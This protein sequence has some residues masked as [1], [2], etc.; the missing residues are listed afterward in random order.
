MQSNDKDPMNRV[1]EAITDETPV[2]WAAEHSA[3]PKHA[4]RL[5]RLR[6]LDRIADVHRTA[7]EPDEGETWMERESHK[8]GKMVAHFAVNDTVSEAV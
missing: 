8:L 4:S 1:A 5:A 2:D 3:T 7:G 6:L